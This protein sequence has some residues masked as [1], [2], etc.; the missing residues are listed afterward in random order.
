MPNCILL[1]SNSDIGSEIATRLEA[2]E[3]TVFRW[4]R[5]DSLENAPKWDLIICAIGTLKP[6][7][8]FFETSWM[9][10]L[11]GFSSNVLIPLRLVHSLYS[12]RNENAAVCFFGG[13]NPYK[14]N[15]KYSG[16][17]AAKAALRMSVRD[18]AAETDL[19][20]FM[21]DTGVVK[22]KIHVEP[23]ERDVY[24]T[25]DEIYHVLKK[26]LTVPKEKVTGLFFFVP[27]CTR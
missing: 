3:W 8:K 4:K 11:T 16:Y 10:W 7:G 25:H 24:T 5:G 18:L 14:A 20:V 21:L 22:T 13:T 2:D 19:R 1:G 26:C 17:A 23:V 27:N 9:D 6:V 12:L 15:P